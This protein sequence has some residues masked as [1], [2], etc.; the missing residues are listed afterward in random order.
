MTIA[1]A[2]AAYL[3]DLEARNIRKSTKAGYQSLFRQLE[4]FAARTGA[5]SLEGIT[6]DA[7]RNWREQ[8][9]CA[10]STQGRR[11][12]QLNA[13]FS[14]AKGEG[15]I[16]RSPLNGIRSP[17]SEARSTMPLSIDEM[18][19]LLEASNGK[20]REQALLLV[21][22]YSGVAISDAA[23]LARSSVHASGEL[24]LR[25]SKSGELVTVLLPM[26]ALAA[27][28]AIAEPDRP[29][30]FWTGVSAPAT[31]ASYWRKRLQGVAA[32]A[33]VEG[34][35]PHRLRDTFAVELLLAG[36]AMQD[37][38]TLLGHSSVR[39]TEQYY[40]PWNHA[41]RSRLVSLVREVHQ[42]DPLLLAFTPKKPAGTAPTAPA[43]ASLAHAAKP[44]R[45]R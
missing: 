2:C 13:F 42:Q 20:P 29:H 45:F 11:L 3:R 39:T 37:V 15:W 17:K 27:L 8:W 6:G 25:R 7:V 28:D 36:M 26:E 16:S 33:D 1:D 30:Y 31:V 19:A 5:E 21:L 43:E 9:D 41:R 24:I 32:A 22:R 38:S 12:Q 40:A 4:A 44:T 34:F 35:H 18:R 14:F 10:Y 23:T